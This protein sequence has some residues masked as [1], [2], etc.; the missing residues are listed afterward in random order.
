MLRAE[1]SP[2]LLRWARDRAGVPYEVLAT[3]FAKLGE[4]E[5][6]ISK[7]PLPMGF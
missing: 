5:N 6:G 7:P 3:R 1:V 2:S 4:W